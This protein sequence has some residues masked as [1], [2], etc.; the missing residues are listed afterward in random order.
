MFPRIPRTLSIAALGLALTCTSLSLAT[1]APTA[2][3][4]DRQQL[5][6]QLGERLQLDPATADAVAQ[7]LAARHQEGQLIKEDA[8]AQAQLLEEAIDAGDTAS[9]EA[10]MAEL[11]R[12]KAD[13]DALHQATQAELRD[14][15]TVEQQAK[16][17]LHHLRRRLQHERAVHHLQGLRDSVR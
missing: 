8:K 15:L 9:M 10:A 14:L 6:A 13:A 1:A 17:T 5:A 11:D 3:A 16:L 7:L 4:P 12:L 2:P